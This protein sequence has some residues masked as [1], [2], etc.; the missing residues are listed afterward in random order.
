MH[1]DRTGEYSI[2]INLKWWNFF[3]S[4][5]D[6]TSEMKIVEYHRKIVTNISMKYGLI[7][8]HRSENF[9]KEIEVLNLDLSIV[10]SWTTENDPTDY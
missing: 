2:R 10:L 8:V 7:P 6:G 4:N 3:R 9:R 5:Q 1:D